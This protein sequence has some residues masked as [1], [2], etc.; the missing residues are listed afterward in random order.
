MPKNLPIL[1]VLSIILLGNES[2]AQVAIQ[3]LDLSLAYL[4][5]SKPSSIN[6]ES[7]ANYLQ[8]ELEI[9]QAQNTRV[10]LPSNVLQFELSASGRIR[11]SK[12]FSH[13][14]R[15]IY[16]VGLQ[17]EKRLTHVANREILIQE[18]TNNPALIYREYDRVYYRFFENLNIAKLHLGIDYRYH[19]NR[20]WNLFSK[21][22][23]SAGRPFPN[24][25]TLGIET[26][27]EVDEIS[28]SGTKHQLQYQGF[29]TEK[30][31]Q[32]AFTLLQFQLV[33]GVDYKPFDSRL[34]F[35]NVSY[36]YSLNHYLIDAS[37]LRDQASGFS[38]G[39]RSSIN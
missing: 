12:N 37:M 18:N 14:F 38:F 27:R 5:S 30:I 31:S 6:S 25:A 33:Q 26:R 3:E 9:S 19:L 24:K 8:Q 29:R 22:V 17:L 39:V 23:I 10:Y 7:I 1:L 15:G 34:I 32:R 20:N 13:E 28:E 35:L 4:R 2:R 36:R 11:H 21:G 16:G